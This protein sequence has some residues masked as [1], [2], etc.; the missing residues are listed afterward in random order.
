MLKDRPMVLI[1]RSVVI[2]VA[3]KPPLNGR[4]G[5]ERLSDENSEQKESTRQTENH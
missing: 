1:T 5:K 4:K 3:A 2:A